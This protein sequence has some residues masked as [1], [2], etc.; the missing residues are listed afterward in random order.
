MNGISEIRETIYCAN[1]HRILLG[2][3]SL[4]G[5]T[6]ARVR[7]DVCADISVYV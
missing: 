4:H 5:S 6:C 7:V 3:T 1:Q 2:L